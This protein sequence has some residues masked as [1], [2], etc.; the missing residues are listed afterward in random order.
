VVEQLV[1]VFQLIARMVAMAREI[2][3][4]RRHDAAEGGVLPGVAVK[5]ADVVGRR[6]H[7]R[8]VQAGRG[9]DAGVAAAQLVGQHID[10]LQRGLH[11]AEL[12]GKRVGGVVAGVHQQPV[13]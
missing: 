3:G 6:A 8:P 4:P 11:A 10:L 5:Q 2:E 13:Q 9:R 12:H 1:V 7:A